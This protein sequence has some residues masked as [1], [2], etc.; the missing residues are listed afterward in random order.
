V[1]LSVSQPALRADIVG[2]PS[3]RESVGCG[4]AFC[5]AA[6]LLALCPRTTC[7]AWA[8]GRVVVAS[9]VGSRGAVAEAV[10]GLLGVRTEVTP[11]TF[12]DG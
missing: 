4:L 1:H 8:G 11:V 10:A 5:A 12:I 2:E 3:G 6:A 9:P 7:R